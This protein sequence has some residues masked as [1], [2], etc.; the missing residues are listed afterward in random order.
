MGEIKQ[1]NFKDFCP[2]FEIVHVPYFLTRNIYDYF[3]QNKFCEAIFLRSLSNGLF[4]TFWMTNFTASQYAVQCR[5]SYFVS[6]RPAYLRRGTS[7]CK[8]R[9]A[10]IRSSLWAGPDYDMK[11]YDLTSFHSVRPTT[12][13]PFE[14]RGFRTCP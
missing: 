11:M 7:S 10:G 6:S 1:N 5:N 12:T 8:A 2:T 4:R 3:I 9:A 14:Y 13:I